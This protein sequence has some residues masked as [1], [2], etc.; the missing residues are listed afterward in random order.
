MERGT[1]MIRN[2]LIG[3]KNY[4]RPRTNITPT[5]QKEDYHMYLLADSGFIESKI[6]KTKFSLP[7]Y[8]N[9]MITSIGHDFLEAAE[10]DTV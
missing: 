3:F 7:I 1:E 8:T 2:L 9:L 4:Y 10:S 5:T 6:K